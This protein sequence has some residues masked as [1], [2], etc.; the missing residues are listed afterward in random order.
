MGY[1]KSKSVEDIMREDLKAYKIWDCG[2]MKFIYINN[3]LC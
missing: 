2:K 3:A 1:D